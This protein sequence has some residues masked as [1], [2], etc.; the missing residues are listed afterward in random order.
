MK[1]SNHRELQ[2]RGVRSVQEGKNYQAKPRRP[3][4]FWGFFR[5][6]FWRADEY[7][8]HLMVVTQKQLPVSN[9]D[10]REFLEEDE[11]FFLDKA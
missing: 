10:K 4:A 2:R 9:T 8:D 1:I 3:M 7:M 11:D 5:G 6:S